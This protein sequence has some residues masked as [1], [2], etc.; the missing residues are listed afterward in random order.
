MAF[1]PQN[2]L[3]PSSHG[4]NTSGDEPTPTIM[5]IEDE[6][7]LASLVQDY[8]LQSGYQVKCFHN[9]KEAW[10][11]FELVK[12]S[13]VVLDLMLPGMDGLALCQA[14]R[15]VSAVP[16]IMVTARSDEIDRLL[17]LELG[18]DDY[19]CKPFSPRE[20]VARVK[21]VLRRAPPTA[22]DQPALQIHSNEQRA[23]LH[24]HLLNLTPSE[25]RLLALMYAHPGQVYS[26]SQLL[27]HLNPEGLDVTDRV[28][29]SHIKNLRKK[30]AET[31]KPTDHE[32]VQ[33]VYGVGYR[34][35]LQG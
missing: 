27:D 3:M 30:I 33:S 16:I 8:L 31:A 25:Y 9:G 17:G 13:L 11:A 28:I 22:Q 2:S 26:R 23:S 5:V 32:W 14:I 20:L 21:T 18:A 4:R 19:V 1:T 12:P 24:G 7:E 15:R 6:I 34:L 29:D 35:E 10:E